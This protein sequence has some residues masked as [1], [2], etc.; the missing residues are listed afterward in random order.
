[1]VT[2]WDL[3]IEGSCINEPSTTY[4]YMRRHVSLESLSALNL[5]FYF[6]FLFMCICLE[7]CSFS[8]LRVQRRSLEPQDKEFQANVGLQIWVLGMN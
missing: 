1:M 5:N 7:F 2:S 8:N 6:Y 4:M 3:R